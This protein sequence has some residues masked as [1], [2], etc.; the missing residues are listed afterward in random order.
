MTKNVSVY[1]V[2]N[3]KCLPCLRF[4]NVLASNR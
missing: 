2:N 3:I 1:K 4:I